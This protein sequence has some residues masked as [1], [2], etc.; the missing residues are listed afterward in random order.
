MQQRN[1]VR[2]IWRSC[3]ADLP[4]MLHVNRVDKPDRNRGSKLRSREGPHGPTPEPP[5]TTD[6]PGDLAMIWREGL[7]RSP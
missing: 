2:H 3:V 6:R 4:N 1:Q 5:L 7:T